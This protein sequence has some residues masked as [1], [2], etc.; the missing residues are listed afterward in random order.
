MKLEKN[1]LPLFLAGTMALSA[2]KADAR[3]WSFLGFAK[4]PS[5]QPAEGHKVRVQK[6]PPD[7]SITVTT[8]SGGLFA[9]SRRRIGE[10][11]MWDT[12][13]LKLYN[14]YMPSESANYIYVVTDTFPGDDV[15]I[16]VPEIYEDSSAVQNRVYAISI[17]TVI[18][19]IPGDT[20]RKKCEYWLRKNPSDRD[21]AFLSTTLTA[22]AFHF[23]LEF[24]VE[25]ANEGDTVDL[26]IFTNDT[27]YKDTFVIVK[28]N[29]GRF[30][31]E[32]DRPIDTVRL[33]I[34]PRPSIKETYAT[35]GPRL[36]K[37]D[38]DIEDEA[39]YCIYDVSG[40]NIYGGKDKKIE[41]IPAGVYFLFSRKREYRKFISQK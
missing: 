34:H 38:K 13:R 8:A 25:N 30:P 36:S 16:Y 40:K 29:V 19:P 23:N 17:R 2:P 12:I 31:N 37:K 22:D 7:T 33:Q 35:N 32:A 9:F 21:T 39:D 26:H 5:G 11:N 27:I 6:I 14:Q 10:F 15:D 24:L 28:R 1:V 3:I 20:T 4:T 18:S 41:K